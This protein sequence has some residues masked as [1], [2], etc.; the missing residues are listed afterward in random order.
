MNEAQCNKWVDASPA[1]LAGLVAHAFRLVRIL[2]Q[3]L[4]AWLH[5]VLVAQVMDTGTEPRP[6][7]AEISRA[8]FRE[9]F[10]QEEP[11]MLK[12]LDSIIEEFGRQSL[13]NLV[14]YCPL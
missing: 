4:V 14:I 8:Q 5:G 1:L 7:D 11:E 2:A 9:L 10:Q 3:C 6:S 13:A 12:F